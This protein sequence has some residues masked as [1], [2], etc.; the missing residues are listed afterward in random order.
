M[1]RIFTANA[2]LQTVAGHIEDPNLAITG[3]VA[4]V[5]A[6]PISGRASYG[7][8]F[9]D[10]TFDNIQAVNFSGALSADYWARG[11]IQVSSLP[12]NVTALM[13]ILNTSSG[14]MMQI[15]CDTAGHLLV[16]DQTGANIATSTFTVTPGTA[17]CV[18]L[19]FNSGNGTQGTGTIEA[20]ING[21]TI[22]SVVGTANTGTLVYKYVEWG[23]TGSN[24]PGITQILYDDLAVN[25]STGAAQNSWC[26][27]GRDILLTPTADSSNTGFSVA[28]GGSTN[29]YGAA[30]TL[31]PTGVAQAS[32]TATSQI[33]DAASNTTDNYVATLQTPTAAGVPAGSTIVLAQG[34]VSHG[35]S[36]T[37]SRTDGVSVASNPVIAEA[38]GTTG[39]TAA[40]A[41]PTGWTTL[42]TAVS[43]APSMTLGTAPTIKFRKAT[44]STDVSM[45]AL[46]ALLVEYVPAAPTNT[47]L[48]SIT[49]TAQQGQ[50]L[51]ANPGTWTQSPATGYGYQWARN[52]TPIT[53]ATN[54]TYTSGQADVGATI[55]V[56]VTDTNTNGSGT[57]TS[58]ATAAV[59][60]SA[61]SG[62]IKRAHGGA[63]V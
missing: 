63:W 13:S 3:T 38:T 62:P 18:E 42:R 35:N 20:K 25:D 43:Y 2:E 50:T 14:V 4:I 60:A 26:G 51:T 31:P 57:A 27:L 30:D 15:Q 7:I 11:R 47:T 34:I 49:G 55:T 5:T 17:Y 59:T 52:G 28:G 58:A 24:N 61:Q 36:T 12:A 10:A 9:T 16:I 48:P 32:A 23:K 19:H 40:A 29:L 37:T 1:S 22:A 54:L 8:P 53:G 56:T 44:A 39:A 33:Q 6:S 21:A 41:W 45:A 46:L